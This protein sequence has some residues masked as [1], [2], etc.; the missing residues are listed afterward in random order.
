M[1]DPAP[2]ADGLRLRHLRFGDVGKETRRLL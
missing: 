2:S 1:T